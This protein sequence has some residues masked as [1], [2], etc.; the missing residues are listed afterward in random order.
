MSDDAEHVDFN[1]VPVRIEDAVGRLESC[2]NSVGQI[3]SKPGGVGILKQ[4]MRSASIK[5]GDK[6]RV[7]CA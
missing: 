3:K 7:R 5:T 1:L 2:Q 6:I 4:A